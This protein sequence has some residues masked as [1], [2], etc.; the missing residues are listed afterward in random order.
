MFLIVR[1]GTDGLVVKPTA[2]LLVD[3]LPHFRR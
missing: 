3:D 2:E 1:G